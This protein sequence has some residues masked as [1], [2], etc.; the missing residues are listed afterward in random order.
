MS[1]RV[2]MLNREAARKLCEALSRLEPPRS[3]YGFGLKVTSQP[4]TATSLNLTRTRAS[5]LFRS[6]RG[7]PRRKRATLVVRGAKLIPKRCGVKDTKLE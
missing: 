1:I 7:K 4:P 6:D 5:R 3:P 2:P